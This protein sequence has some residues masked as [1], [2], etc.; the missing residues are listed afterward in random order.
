MSNLDVS[1][2]AAW[3]D[4]SGVTMQQQII[5]VGEEAGEV[6][7]AYLGYIGTPRKGVCAT[8]RD[9]LDEL[10]DVAITAMVTI[11]LMG[12]L[13]EVTVAQRIAEVR[14]RIDPAS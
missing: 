8:R 13:P 12:Y 2:L 1:E 3:L 6:A 11:K 9:V 4:D 10:A 7:K 14:D 5:K